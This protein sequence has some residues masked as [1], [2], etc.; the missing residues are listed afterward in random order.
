MKTVLRKLKWRATNSGATLAANLLNLSSQG[1]SSFIFLYKE[2]HMTYLGYVVL[3]TYL[4]S[5]AYL[6]CSSMNEK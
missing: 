1:T 4:V 6:L 5:E 2:C 3:L